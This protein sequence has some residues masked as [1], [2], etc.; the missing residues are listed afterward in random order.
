MNHAKDRRFGKE[1]RND[2]TH[3]AE[4]RNR[5]TSFVASRTKRKTVDVDPHHLD[6]EA[7]HHYRITNENWS[8]TRPFSYLE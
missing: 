8:G 5:P 2:G 6:S 3:T 4:G 1:A 7:A